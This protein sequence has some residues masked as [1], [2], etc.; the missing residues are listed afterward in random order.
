MINDNCGSRRNIKIQSG[1][2]IND[3][4]IR[5]SVVI[6]KSFTPKTTNNIILIRITA[7]MICT[8]DGLLILIPGNDIMIPSDIYKKNRA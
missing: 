4:I 8:V 3:K 2:M 7:N 6:R 5:L 1:A